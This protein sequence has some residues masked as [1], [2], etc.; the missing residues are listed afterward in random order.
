MLYL[1]VTHYSDDWIVK[2]V[3]VAA[4]LLRKNYNFPTSLKNYLLKCIFPV[5]Y[6]FILILVNWIVSLEWNTVTFIDGFA[7]Y[8]IAFG[9]AVNTS[10]HI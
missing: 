5:A 9:S 10:K 1:K 6:G 2:K 8:I 4:Y 3:A 7:L